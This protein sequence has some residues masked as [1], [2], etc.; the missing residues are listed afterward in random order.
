MP[1]VRNVASAVGP[2]A[3]PKVPSPLRSQLC[4]AMSDAPSGS[5]AVEVNCTFW[6][7]V[8][9]GGLN[10]KSGT[11]RWSTW[12]R[13]VN[14]AL[15]PLLSV[16]RRPT[17]TSP[18]VVSVVMSEL[19]AT[20]GS[21]TPSPLKSHSYVAIVPSESA[22]DVAEKATRWP[23][24]G[25]WKSLPPNVLR[26]RAAYVKAAVGGA[27]T[28]TVCCTKRDAPSESVT[29]RVTVLLPLVAYGWEGFA[30]LLTAPSP[31]FHAN[32]TAPSGSKD[33]EPSKATDWLIC[34]TV[35]DQVKPGLGGALTRRLCETVAVSPCASVIVIV[36]VFE[37]G[38]A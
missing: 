21:K 24:N 2:V 4:D 28:R 33:E 32:V 18:G 23:T 38:A 7:V 16:T 31:K 22:L 29:V 20:G 8:G 1:A 3:S 26:S 34:G 6:P 12:M 11:G 25:T 10:V 35:G 5:V 14:V 36:T 13:L 30:A 37:P 17:V 27:L 15:A 9:F 19:A